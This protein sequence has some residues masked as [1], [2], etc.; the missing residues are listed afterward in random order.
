MDDII[1]KKKFFVDENLISFLVVGWD[2][3]S[4]EWLGYNNFQE[5]WTFSDFTRIKYEYPDI[6]KIY[7]LE[8]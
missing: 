4:K 1:S 6:V 8:F 2:D 3:D 5:N 7:D